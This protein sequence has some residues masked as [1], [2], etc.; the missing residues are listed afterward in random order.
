MTHGARFEPSHPGMDLWRPE[1]DHLRWSEAAWLGASAG[2][3]MHA[4][5]SFFS[6]VLPSLQ[7]V[8][9]F[10]APATRFAEGLTAGA[11][12]LG[13]WFVLLLSQAFFWALVG[14]ALLA[15]WRE[16]VHLVRL[17]RGSVPDG[18]RG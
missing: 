5:L 3:G 7:V 11:A 18:T 15:A 12:P 14:L 8:L 4:I 13:R 16:V 17:V 1:G 6:A 9:V 10:F 2:L